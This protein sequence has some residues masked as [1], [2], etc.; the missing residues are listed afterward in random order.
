MAAQNFAAI[1]AYLRAMKRLW[2][3]STGLQRRREW[4]AATFEHAL[5]QGVLPLPK[6]QPSYVPKVSEPPRD[7]RDTSS[8]VL[9]EQELER[10][11]R[12]NYGTSDPL[13]R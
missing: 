6:V 8:D 5:A 9:N 12:I 13:G 10:V 2:P 1:P 7:L 4:E 11:R 3:Y